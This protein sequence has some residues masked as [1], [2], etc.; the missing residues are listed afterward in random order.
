[1][2]SFTIV[3]FVTV[4]YCKIRICKRQCM[5]HIHKAHCM[6]RITHYAVY[7]AHRILQ[8]AFRTLQIASRTL[9]H[10]HHTFHKCT[11]NVTKDTVLHISYTFWTLHRTHYGIHIFLQEAA[12]RT[13]H[14]KIVIHNEHFTLYYRP[15]LITLCNIAHY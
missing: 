5:L 2:S 8:M 11:L 9:Q 15:L 7:I 14:L 6:L 3:V 1:M 4:F 12:F 13:L 10:A